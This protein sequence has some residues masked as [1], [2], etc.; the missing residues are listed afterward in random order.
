MEGVSLIL[1]IEPVSKNIDMY[2][3]AYPLTLMEVGSFVK[4][5]L[6]DLTKKYREGMSDQ[7][8]RRNLT[9]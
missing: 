4:E 1:F 7:R 2:V 5:V 8:G 3:P 6:P 9:W